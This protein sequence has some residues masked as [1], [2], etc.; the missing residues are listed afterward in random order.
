LKWLS[1]WIKAEKNKRNIFKKLV[2]DSLKVLRMEERYCGDFELDRDEEIDY[3]A[4]VKEYRAANR[5]KMEMF[6][7]DDDIKVL[8]QKFKNLK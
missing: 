7:A 1:S 5:M 4:E 3:R 2:V 6:Q 8:K